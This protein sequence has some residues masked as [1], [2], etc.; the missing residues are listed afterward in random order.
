[1]ENLTELKLTDLVLDR[2]EANSLMDRASI[3][4]NQSLKQ[5]KAINFT[6]NHCPL[7][8]IGMLFNLEV[9]DNILIG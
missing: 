6:L 1:M 4:L 2:Y 8:Q 9:F 5:F 3:C 7:R